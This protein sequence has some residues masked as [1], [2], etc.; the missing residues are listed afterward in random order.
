[1]EQNKALVEAQIENYALH[2]NRSSAMA[3]GQKQGHSK[4]SGN[5][6]G[7]YDHF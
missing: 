3:K 5:K 6:N 7:N 1:M 2:A 4:G